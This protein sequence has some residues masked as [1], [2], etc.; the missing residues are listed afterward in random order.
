MRPRVASLLPSATEIVCALS[1]IDQLCGVSHECDF[2]PELA[3][4]VAAGELPVLTGAR[5][6]PPGKLGVGAQAATPAGAEPKSTAG[7][8][9]Y[10]LTNSAAIDTRLREL[11]AQALS[12]YIVDERALAAC[13]PDLILT[14][15]LCE[16]CAVSYAEICRAASYLSHA[17]SVVSSHPT[18]L[19]DIW[20][21]IRAVAAAIGREAEGTALLEQLSAR[22]EAV[23]LRSNAA[24]SRPAVLT[25]EWIEPPMPGGLWMAELVELAGGVP[26]GDQAGAKTHAFTAEQLAALQPE[27]VVVKPCGFT[28]EQGL[29]ELETLR[30]VVPWDDWPACRTGRVYVA[31]GSAYF[32][33]PGP[34]IVDSTELL[35]A[36][37]QP[38]LFPDFRQRYAHAVAPIG[39]DLAVVPW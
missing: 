26:L 2:P 36:C 14:Q 6:G 15:D 29:A 21:D 34:R 8:T 38:E 18:S 10:A 9:G 5:L 7:A 30:R 39:P 3:Q 37:V 4:R 23:R 33:R 16:V 31:D 28:L 11:V 32:N 13:R 12:V 20:A 25:L 24:A 35:A 1:G 17:A 19:A 27:V 22:V